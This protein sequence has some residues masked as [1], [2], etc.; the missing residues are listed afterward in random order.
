MSAVASFFP[1]GEAELPLP[2][3]EVPVAEEFVAVGRPTLV[4]VA[5]EH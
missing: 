4:P 1:V 2:D 5:F 3:P